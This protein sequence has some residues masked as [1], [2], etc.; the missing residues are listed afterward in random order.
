MGAHTR[1]HSFFF[2]FSTLSLGRTK[3]F[4]N[5][6]CG[7]IDTDLP[8]FLFS[9]FFFFFVVVVVVIVVVVSFTITL[10]TFSNRP[11]TYGITTQPLDSSLSVSR[12]FFPFSF[13]FSLSLS[14]LLLLYLC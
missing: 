4:L 7:R 1:H 3:V 11:L 6:H 13:F 2:S 10:A 9:F 5:T 12:F 14:L 8:G